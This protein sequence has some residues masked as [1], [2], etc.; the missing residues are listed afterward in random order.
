MKNAPGNGGLLLSLLTPRPLATLLGPLLITLQK[1]RGNA[2]AYA[3]LLPAQAVNQGRWKDTKV[4][5]CSQ[6]D[7][8]L[9]S[10]TTLYNL[11]T[12]CW[13]SAPREQTSL[14]FVFQWLL[15]LFLVLVWD[16]FPSPHF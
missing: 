2:V 16:M 7:T 6:R 3:H 5:F 15:L 8:M 11:R 12:S 1:A 4:E 13:L 14:V 10:D 9:T